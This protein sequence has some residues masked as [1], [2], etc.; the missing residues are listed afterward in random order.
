MKKFMKF[1]AVLA[2][3]MMLCTN[4]PAVSAED[5]PF[6]LFGYMNGD[7]LEQLQIL[8]DKGWM[9]GYVLNRLRS[10]DTNENTPYYV[11]TYH[12][13]TVWMQSVLN[14]ETGEIH[15]EAQHIDEYLMYLA[16]MR[17]DKL[18]YVLRS[19]IDRTAAEQKA[20]E[21]VQKYFPEKRPYECAKGTYLLTERDEALRTEERADSLMHELAEAGLISAFYTWGETAEYKEIDHG[22]LTVYDADGYIREREQEE[23]KTYDWAA[24]EAWVRKH[25][26]ECE[27]VSIADKD[28]ELGKKL[29]ISYWYHE[30]LW[31]NTF[32]AVIPP[33]DISFADHFALAM[34]LYE[35][36]GLSPCAWPTS[37]ESEPGQMFGKNSLA[38]TGDANLDCSVDVSD[39]VLAARF[40]AEDREAVITDQ[41]KENADVNGDGSVTAD[42]T[43]LILKKIAKKI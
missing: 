15:K 35:Q 21:I 31:G 12:L 41:G 33:E 18:Q 43:E 39:A 32:Y 36:F 22:F 1:A 4:C 17:E 2:S 27:F 30:L 23:G 38:V 29:D 16:A 7:H 8:D 9:K 10:N 13:D 14:T 42:D 24:I 34:E 20:E 28:S 11:C 19:D 3:A 26:P 37:L 6:H 40:A 25:H 5:L